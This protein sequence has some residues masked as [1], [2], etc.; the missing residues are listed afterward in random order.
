MG[1]VY[2]FIHNFITIGCYLLLNVWDICLVY[3]RI[4][5]T[6]RALQRSM[7]FSCLKLPWYSERMI[8]HINFWQVQ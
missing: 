1:L 5:K 7:S 6:I 3:L 4:R 2:N 8:I